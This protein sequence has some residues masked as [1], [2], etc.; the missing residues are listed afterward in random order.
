MKIT[1]DSI[2]LL[3]ASARSFKNS[4]GEEIKYDQAVLLDDDGN[5][6]EM[7]IA[8]DAIVD[9]TLEKVEGSAEF[10]ASIVRKD[11]G[12]AVKLRLLSFTP[13]GE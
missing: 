7:T 3:K 5:K 11:N 13:S 12:T 4:A 2:T 10:D 1:T 6:F 9:M 8:K